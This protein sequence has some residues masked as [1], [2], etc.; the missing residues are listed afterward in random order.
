M[1]SLE[2]MQGEFLDTPCMAI[3]GDTIRYRPAGGSWLTLKAYVDHRD[4]ATSFDGSQVIAQD[5]LVQALRSDIPVKPGS[6][7]RITLPKVPG[8]MFKP[9]NVGND[10]SGDY[11]E[12]ALQAVN[13]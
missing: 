12:F 4:S 2:D 13:A 1:T 6:G 8:K 7:A 3:L 10:V 5:I 11:W 9:I